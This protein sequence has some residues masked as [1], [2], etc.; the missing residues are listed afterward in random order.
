MPFKA[1]TESNEL[2]TLRILNTRM[3]LSAE[4]QKH[5]LNLEKG[6]EG[7]IQFDLL[8]EKLQCECL[9][10]NDLLLEVNHTKF[11]IDSLIILQEVIYVFE[12]KNFE[13]D[14]VYKPDSFYTNSGTEI[15]NPQDQLKR[16]KILFRQLLQ[17]LGF[18]LQ[19]EA[20]VVFV[21]P[22]FSLYESPKSSPF[23]FPTQLNR[24][25]KKLNV[26]HSKL[27]ISHTKL[28]E[29]LVSL[30][31]TESLSSQ[32]PAYQ[33][34]QLKRKLTC[35]KCKGFSVFQCGK[36][37]RCNDCGQEE[38]V[39][40]AVLRSVEELRLLFPTKKITTNLVHEWCMV[41]ESKKTIRR[42]LKENLKTHGQK[43]WTHYD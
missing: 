31:I 18:S 22:E 2:K 6:Y 41:V 15:R 38:E 10:I 39:T 11:Q 3:E 9:I 23:I 35:K 7:E 29:K 27:N 20:F 24:F 37:I 16:C 12:V 21:N 34:D 13:G 25:M 32:I 42:I 43:T 19:I 8:T 14:Y 4:E 33:Y 40:S 36:K 5:Y 17:Y 26:Q 1:R 28:A 30:H